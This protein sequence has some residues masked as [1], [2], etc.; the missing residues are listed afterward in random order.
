M[1]TNKLIDGILHYY[2]LNDGKYYPYS[3]EALTV[4]YLEQDKEI[5]QLKKQVENLKSIVRH[6]NPL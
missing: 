3:L 4:G 6:E 2:F 1:K 5:S